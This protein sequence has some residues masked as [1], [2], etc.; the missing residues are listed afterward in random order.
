MTVPTS[1]NGLHEPFVRIV[2]DLE[3]PPRV[4]ARAFSA[5]PEPRIDRTREPLETSYC[6]PSVDCLDPYGM[7][8]TDP[9]AE[10]RLTARS[11]E[12]TEIEPDTH[13]REDPILSPQPSST[14]AL[15]HA[16][17]LA[18]AWDDGV[19]HLSAHT[20]TRSILRIASNG[21]HSPDYCQRPHSSSAFPPTHWVRKKNNAV[22]VRRVFHQPW[23]LPRV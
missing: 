8:A 9:G 10:R 15:S 22:I 17:E 4:R 12:F 3:G 18:E 20:E 6:P 7:R 2:V 14:E 11:L 5:H 21:K 23:R 16:P 13:I 1:P 19:R